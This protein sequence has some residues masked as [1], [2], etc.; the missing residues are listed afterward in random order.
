VWNTTYLESNGSEELES[1]CR[2]LTVDESVKA[3]VAF[4]SVS[5]SHDA[6]YV[7]AGS[8]DGVIR[9]W[10]LSAIP[11]DTL[12]LEGAKL[13]DRLSGHEHSVYSVKFMDGLNPAGKGDALVSGS[14]DK[15]LKRWEVG[16]F[17]GGVRGVGLE[18][19]GENGSNCVKTFQGHKVRDHT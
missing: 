9:V 18:G 12:E 11:D 16:P 8:L 19:H 3:D 13:V 15:T 5:I 4:T 1:S 6:R 7:A 10:D 17:D 2:V 14:L